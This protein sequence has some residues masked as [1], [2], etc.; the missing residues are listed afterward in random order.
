MITV[1]FAFDK[2][3]FFDKEECQ[4]YEMNQYV[5]KLKQLGKLEDQV[6]ESSF[7][8]YKI[9][10]NGFFGY[11]ADDWEERIDKRIDYLKSKEL[12]K[13][14]PKTTEMKMKEIIEKYSYGKDSG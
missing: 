14:E 4:A 2:K 6:I 10:W 8:E 12:G 9:D 3:P 1:Y 13:E 5:T 7:G 11:L